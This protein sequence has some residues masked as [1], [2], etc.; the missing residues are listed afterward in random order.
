M[1]RREL[2]D[3]F[4][5]REVDCSKVLHSRA[6]ATCLSF[7]A[8]VADWACLVDMGGIGWSAR[9]PLILHSGRPMLYVDRNVTTFYNEEPHAMVPWRHYIPVA[10][11]LSDLPRKARWVLEN[12]SASESIAMRAK[13]LAQ[14]HFTLTAAIQALV[15]T[16]DKMPAVQPAANLSQSPVAYSLDPP[17]WLAAFMKERPDG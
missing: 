4:E 9:V 11:D 12:P 7:E 2:Q 14:R 1:R 16:L 8:Q 13:M 3:L 5:A 17:E 6:K 15:A 10:A